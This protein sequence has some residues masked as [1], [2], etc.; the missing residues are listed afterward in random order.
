MTTFQP[1]MIAK[2]ILK[3]QDKHSQTFF[4]V[5]LGITNE[6]VICNFLEINSRKLFL[7]ADM[8]FLGNL[9]PKTTIYVCN[10]FLPRVY[11]N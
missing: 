3:F 8:K 1:E 5:I 7:V 11:T 10:T 6:Y 4:H 2:L 9:I